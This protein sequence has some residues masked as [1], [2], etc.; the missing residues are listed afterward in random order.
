MQKIIASAGLF[1]LG[2]AVLPAAESVLVSTN[3]APKSWSV[4][5]T[6]GGFYDD[7]VATQPNSYGG[8]KDNGGF[9][10]SPG[11]SFKKDWGRT[12][13]DLDLVYGYRYYTEGSFFGKEHDETWN[14]GLLFDHKFNEHWRIRVKDSFVASNEPDDIDNSISTPLRGDYYGQ[15]NHGQVSILTQFSENFGTEFCFDT[16][17]YHYRQPGVPDAGSTAALLNRLEHYPFL[18][19]RARLSENVIGLVGYQLGCLD[20]YGQDS[21]FAGVP[22]SGITGNTRDTYSHYFYGGVDVAVNS[23]FTLQGKLGLHYTHWD[24]VPNTT[25]LMP[26][27]NLSGTYQF[28]PK[29]SVRFGVKYDRAAT[30][31]IGNN[32]NTLTL[33]QAYL[34]VQAK[35]AHQLCSKVTGNLSGQYHWSVLHGNPG[36]ADG[37]SE[38]FYSIGAGVDYEFARHWTA[39]ASYHF[40]LLNSGVTSVDRSFDRNRVELGVRATF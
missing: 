24:N 23:Q 34:L 26:Y 25:D 33:D 37:Q 14:L 35:L 9:V 4:S 36:S 32:W 40:D 3:D 15:H 22:G 13:L 1:T 7:N 31:I 20:N 10:V 12:L 11:G 27:V 16:H 21:L 8:K 28:C 2:A 5:A 30:D 19:L 38:N 39:L 6:V 18:D 29:T 17:F